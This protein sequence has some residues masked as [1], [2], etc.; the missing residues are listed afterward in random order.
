MKVEVDADRL[1]DY[2]WKASLDCRNC[3]AKSEECFF[4]KG[5]NATIS[6]EEQILKYIKGDQNE[7]ISCQR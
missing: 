2:I 4:R 1:I 7:Q 5:K 6:C 3:P